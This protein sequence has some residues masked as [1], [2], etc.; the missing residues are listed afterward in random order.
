MAG[1]SSESSRRKTSNDPM[2]RAQTQGSEVAA[3]KSCPGLSG[4]IVR[5]ALTSCQTR[6]RVGLELQAQN[7][8][9]PDEN[10]PSGCCFHPLQIWVTGPRSPKAP[11]AVYL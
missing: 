5:G 10:S 9:D 2:S 11:P 8:T 7:L 1:L 6:H 3:G 4:A